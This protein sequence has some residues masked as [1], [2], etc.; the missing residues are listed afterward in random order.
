LRLGGAVAVR[1][2][3]ELAQHPGAEDD[4]QS[5]Q[6]T[7]HLCVRV[8]LKTRFELLGQGSDLDDQ[9][10]DDRQAG[11]HRYPIAVDTAEGMLSCSERR[12]PWICA[13]RSSIRR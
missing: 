7:D 8:L 1:L 2:V 12:A 9:G 4:P 5:W 6:G 3:A 13:V 10:G 11:R